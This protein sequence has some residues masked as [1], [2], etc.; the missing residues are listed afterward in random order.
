MNRLIRIG[1]ALA[2]SAAS[3][4][5]AAQ[6]GPPGPPSP[7]AQAASA[8]GARQGLYKLMATQFGPIGGM[9][10]GTVPFDAAVVARNAPRIATL[11]EI[12]PEMFTSDTHTF[13]ATKSAALPAIWTSQADFKSKA[14]ALVKAANDLG[15]AAKGGDKAATLAAAGAVGKACGSCHD[16]YR[17][18][19]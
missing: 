17:Q 19:P 5:A 16:N 4:L 14:D 7:E 8:I 1:V 10:R 6:G 9:L 11:G 13:T 12:I 18:K 15:A 3:A 2:A